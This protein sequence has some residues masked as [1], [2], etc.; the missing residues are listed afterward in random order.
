M[1]DPE[2]LER[3][4]NEANTRGHTESFAAQRLSVSGDVQAAQ[5]SLTAAAQHYQR[6]GRSWVDAAGAWL[7]QSSDA[8]PA[9][10][11]S[12]RERAG[13]DYGLA[14]SVYWYGGRSYADA[15]DF[16]HAADLMEAAARAYVSQSA[17][18]EEDGRIQ[19]AWT[20]RV[21]ATFR[22]L[23]AQRY[24]Q[25]ASGFRSNLATNLD[26]VGERQAALEERAQ[27]AELEQRAVAAGV[28][29]N[30]HGPEYHASYEGAYKGANRS[31][32]K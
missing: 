11:Q 19:P 1:P 13:A 10:G 18:W 26:A 4:A 9:G 32:Y 8:A 12:P 17:L 25:Q 14:A 31:A 27:A 20:L 6:S 2:Q 29:V 7:T 3:A 23:D 21:E 16:E 22:Y 5:E 24:Y 28:N 30:Q 15:Y